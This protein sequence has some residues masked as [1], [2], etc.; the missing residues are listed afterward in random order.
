MKKILKDNFPTLD[1]IDFFSG[2]VS[3]KGHLIKYYPKK[4]IKNLF[5][6][7][8]GKFIKNKLIIKEFYKEGDIKT[9]REWSFEKINDKN[10]IGTEENVVGKIKVFCNDNI[11]TMNYIFK[12]A[13]RKHNMHINVVDEMYQVSNNEIINTTTISKYK[14]V[15]ARSFLLYK[16]L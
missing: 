3:A 14:I 6:D 4:Q 16:K 10:F 12:I 13:F 2:K 5:I 7:F 15:L 1:F 11:L 8:E 9:T